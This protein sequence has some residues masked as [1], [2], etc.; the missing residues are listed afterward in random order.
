MDLFRVKLN[1]IDHYQAVPTDFDPQLPKGTSTSQQKTSTRVPVIRVFGAT[2]TGQKVCAHIHGAFPYLYVAYEG[3]LTPEEGKQVQSIICCVGLISSAVASY[4]SRLQASIDLALAV[5]YRRNIS[6]SNPV[7]VAHISLVKGV[8]FYGYYVGYKFFLKIYMFNPLH[9][10]RLAD[11]LRQGTIMKSFIQPYESHMQYLAQWMCDYNLYGC[12]YID[13]KAVKFRGPVPDLLDLNCDAHRWH[14][15][16]IPLDRISD[17]SLLPRQSH[18]PL[19]VDICVQ[20]IVNRLDI[21]SRP[22]HHDFVERENPL[23]LDQKLVPSMAGLWRDETKRRKA[24]IDD[25]ASSPFPREVLISM[26]ADPRLSQPGG[27]IHEEEYSNKVPEIIQDEKAKSGEE[28]LIFAT[29][30][31][32]TALELHVKTVFE[33]VE[34][35][36]PENIASLTAIGRFTQAEYTALAAKN[37][38]AEV[39]ESRVLSF[40]EDDFRDDSDEEAFHNFQGSQ[41]Q[42]RTSLSERALTGGTLQTNGNLNTCSETGLSPPRSE[43]HV[44]PAPFGDAQGPTSSAEL[45]ALGVRKVDDYSHVNE[46]AFEIP[47]ELVSEAVVPI[48]LPVKRKTG[49]L[50][51]MPKSKKLRQYK[52]EHFRNERM[53]DSNTDDL[54]IPSVDSE[55]PTSSYSEN[56]SSRQRKRDKKRCAI[57]KTVSVIEL[58]LIVFLGTNFSLTQLSRIH[59]IQPQFE[60]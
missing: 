14:D 7:Y 44:D 23:P 25:Q 1:C 43:K 46:D 36:F 28:Q 17:E 2:E 59:K 40:K 45:E 39:D 41:R 10:T 58:S 35:L 16:S 29:F 48:K 26:S 57:P 30:V 18:C 60:D 6:E 20:D 15:Q 50:A 9:M 24:R 42:P 12:A 49:S 8:P 31:E 56:V 34:D 55:S 53:S 5:S 21:T 52:H 13:C 22:L 11:L 47:L 51:S 37:D 4:I 19:E 33:S 32:R 54:L 3:S 27:W 38:E